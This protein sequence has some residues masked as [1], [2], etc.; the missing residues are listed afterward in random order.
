MPT[1][2][3]NSWTALTRPGQAKSYF[4]INYPP[5]ELDANSYSKVNALWLAELSRLVYNENSSIRQD[6][7]Q[8]VKMYETRFF[9]HRSNYAIIVESAQLAVLV[10]R[11]TTTWQD[12]W[13]NL[14]TWP[15]VWPL[16]GQVHSGFKKAL[17]NIWQAIDNYLNTLK[18]PVFYTGHSLGG[19]LAILAASKRPPKS[20]YTFG[21]PLVGDAKFVS[22]LTMSGYR[23]VNNRDIFATLPPT[24]IGQFWPAGEL[25]YIARHHQRLA[26][27]TVECVFKNRKSSDY[28]LQELTNYRKWYYPPEFLYDHAPVNYVAHLERLL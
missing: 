10:F 11:G 22:T 16:G 4:N 19:A 24:W 26:N 15:T 9:E 3:D 2:F 18:V 21:A 28:P 27:Q 13:F 7:L 1:L 17:E 14:Q 5:L 25:H 20:W 23:V 6:Y 12:W 8:H